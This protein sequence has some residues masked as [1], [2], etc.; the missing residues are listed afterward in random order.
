MGIEGIQFFSYFLICFILFFIL[1]VCTKNKMKVIHFALKCLEMG[2]E[3]LQKKIIIF[4]FFYF[5]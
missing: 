2:L 5:F 1:Y 3:G 4:Y